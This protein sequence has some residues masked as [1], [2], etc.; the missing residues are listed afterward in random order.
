MLTCWSSVCWNNSCIKCYI[1]HRKGQIGCLCQQWAYRCIFPDDFV[2]RLNPW[3]LCLGDR[4]DGKAFITGFC[5]DKYPKPIILLDQAGQRPCGVVNVVIY[6]WGPYDGPCLSF[7]CVC[8][9][10]CWSQLRMQATFRTILDR[11]FEYCFFTHKIFYIWVNIRL[12]IHQ[13][14]P[15]WWIICQWSSQT[16]RLSSCKWEGSEREDKEQGKSCS[17]RKATE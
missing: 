10:K 1:L 7:V 8:V 11:C 5:T 14:F 9:Y 16:Q 13:L 4:H 6:S 12:L 17:C 3:Q 2:L 15:L